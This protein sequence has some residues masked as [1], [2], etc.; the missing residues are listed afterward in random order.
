MMGAGRRALWVWAAGL[1]L[2]VL[3]GGQAGA[4]AAAGKGEGGIA[5]TWQGTLHT[6]DGQ[7]LRVVLKIAKDEKG[8]GLNGI[9]YSLDLGGATMTGDAVS[10]AG[11][12]LRFANRYSG[13]SYEGKMAADG[14]SISGTTQQNGSTISLVLERATPETEWAI[15]AAP[16]KIPAMA[17]DA[18]PGI[19]VATVKLSSPDLHKSGMTLRGREIV[20]YGYT[21]DDMVKFCYDLGA[22]QLANEPEWMKTE[23][24]DV[25]VLPDQPGFPSVEQ[26]Q[27]VLKEVLGERFGLR[28]HEEQK[29]MPVYV[30]TV[31]KEGAKLTKSAD[32]SEPGEMSIGPLGL[33]RAHNMTMNRFAAKMQAMVLDRPVVDRTGLAGKWD[34]ELKWLVD[35]TQFGGQLTKLQAADEATQSRPPLFTAIREQLGLQLESEKSDVPVMVIDHVE[36]PTPN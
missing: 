14:N 20:V 3:A 29:E 35:D 10:F 16:R 21:L 30:L 25:N 11:G 22:K 7:N 8:D 24:F 4:P 19:E 9:L 36:Q 31:A 18:K 26:F 17:A 28:F 23:R 13:F 15:P 27:I 12:T 33:V 34:F 6:P 5:G 2:G 32:P 1:A